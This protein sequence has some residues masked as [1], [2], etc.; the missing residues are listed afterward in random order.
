MVALSLK[1]YHFLSL[2]ST[3]EIARILS[4]AVSVIFILLRIM[5][6]L[7]FAYYTLRCHSPSFCRCKNDGPRMGTCLYKSDLLEGKIK[8]EYLTYRMFGGQRVL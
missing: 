7:T 1:L 6:H 3:V 2:S 5:S 8:L 4:R